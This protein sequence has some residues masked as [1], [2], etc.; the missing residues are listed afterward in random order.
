MAKHEYIWIHELFTYLGVHKNNDWESQHQN[1][2]TWIYMDTWAVHL[3]VGV[4]NKSNDWESQHQNGKTWIYTDTWAVYLFVEKTRRLIQGISR[5]IASLEKK[6]Q[7]HEKW[8][9]RDPG[10]ANNPPSKL[11]EWT[12]E[13]GDE[14]VKEHLGEAWDLRYDM[15]L[16][17]DYSLSNRKFKNFLKGGNNGCHLQIL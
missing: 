15:I 3:F 17:S 16:V 6:I 1:G 5:R 4:H 14:A 9:I 13:L 8:K 12:L 11:C 7:K 10:K 2:K